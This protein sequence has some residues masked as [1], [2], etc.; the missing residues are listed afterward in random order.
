LKFRES[1]RERESGLKLTD[2]VLEVT[3]NKTVVGQMVPGLGKKDK[4]GLK[5][6]GSEGGR[7][8]HNS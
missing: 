1:Y 7:R 8:E 5:C 6:Q 3:I 2:G 4:A